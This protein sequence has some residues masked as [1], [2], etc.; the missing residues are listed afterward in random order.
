M[1]A[2]NKPMD[3]EEVEVIQITVVASSAGRATLERK[4]K[5]DEGEFTPNGMQ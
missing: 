3:G 5:D 2:I 1:V 4:N